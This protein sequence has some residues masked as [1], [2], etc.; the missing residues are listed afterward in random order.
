MLLQRALLGSVALV[1]L[2]V[3]GV[4]YVH[5]SSNAPATGNVAWSE[6]AGEGTIFPACGSATVNG[7]T[8]TRGPGSTC[9]P[10]VYV[11]NVSCN[12]TTG[13]GSASLSWNF[14]EYP[15]DV[16]TI[17][18]S[19]PSVSW[20]C[21]SP[22]NCTN[23]G[24]HSAT[25]LAAGSYSFVAGSP[26]ETA[27]HG[28][29]ITMNFTV[30]SCSTTPTPD[31]D[32]DPDPEPDPTPPSGNPQQSVA[33]SSPTA[34]TISW[35]STGAPSYEVAY[36]QT[37]EASDCPAGWSW[38]FDGAGLGGQ[39]YIKGVTGTSIGISGL[40]T[41]KAYTAYVWAEDSSGTVTDW[42]DHPTGFT[43]TNAPVV[44]TCA[45]TPGLA[46]CPCTMTNICGQSSSG[47]LV[48][49]NGACSVPAPPNT[50][51]LATRCYFF[52]AS[53]VN[54]GN[55]PV[56][57]NYVGG[58]QT[59]ELDDGYT[60]TWNFT[61][62]T[63]GFTKTQVVT[64][65][66]G[67]NWSNSTFGPCQTSLT[68]PG[69][70]GD[71]D[72]WLYATLQVQ[73]AAGTAA[74]PGGS[75]N[76]YVNA[77]PYYCS[78]TVTGSGLGSFVTWTAYQNAGGNYQTV[79][80][81]ISWTGTDGFFANT[82]PASWTYPT[83]GIKNATASI[84]DADGVTITNV[85]CSVGVGMPDLSAGN[86]SPTT[87]TV[88]VATTLSAII[89]NA[90]AAT[91][92]GFTDLF[93]INPGSI[94]LDF[95]SIQTL[96]TYAS[97]ALVAGASN[98][99]TASYTFPSAGDYYVRAC[100]DTNASNVGSIAESNETNNCSAVWTR[101]TVDGGGGP[102]P[103]GGG[104]P[105]CSPSTQSILPGGTAT[106]TASGGTGSPFSW[107]DA[108]NNPIGSGSPFSKLYATPG[109]YAVYVEDSAAAESTTCQVTVGCSGLSASI[110]ANPAR[111]PVGGGSTA[112][113]WSASGVNTSCK[114]TENNVQI[115][116]LGG[117][118]GAQ[119][120][121]ASRS[122][123]EQTRYCISCDGAT[124]GQAG[125]DCVTVNVSSQF[126]PF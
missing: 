87:A 6:V 17:S 5:A 81:S 100:A 107:F 30:P 55:A 111:F 75:C 51:P 50:C 26:G 114:I 53:S 4:W 66:P 40:T 39:C 35:T 97:A 45:T 77:P 52:P 73:T 117:S 47:T 49:N 85:S 82:N 54:Q 43:C 83:A 64:V 108:F 44:Q 101:V 89:S 7:S 29:P 120:D 65:A 112:V 79:A 113:T 70:P 84:S 124:T 122:V 125:H 62:P 63:L 80:D 14:S 92:A 3:G 96:R 94:P 38:Y 67:S 68:A 58:T 74:S 11:G 10:P 34:A 15:G 72:S 25:G 115:D 103:G 91:G 98:T 106:W 22:F 109:T 105:V 9:A 71:P 31:P 90:N 121:N 78:G 23:T 76:L 110:N 28:G 27:A 69:S 12:S 1:A 41:D 19:G 37:D 2:L 16:P 93:E 118:C 13:L 36:L 20:A 123:A 88:G 56:A 95:A 99:A 102:P 46:G 126:V 61:D 104:A 21:D 86:I 116:T 60:C 18:L 24:S 33:C 48:A 59:S 32:P 42:T 119:G 57:A 8:C